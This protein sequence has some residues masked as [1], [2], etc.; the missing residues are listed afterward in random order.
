M[1]AVLLI[2]VLLAI[3]FLTQWGTMWMGKRACRTIIK[4]LEGKGAYTPESATPLPYTQ[5]KGILHIG[6][7]DY[8]P[9]AL[10]YLIHREIIRMTDDGR[11]YLVATAQNVRL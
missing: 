4:D 2:V 1:E 5:K 10:Q 6:A 11:Y 9:Q 8:K 3:Y 7:R